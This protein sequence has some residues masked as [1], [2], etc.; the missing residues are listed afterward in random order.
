LSDPAMEDAQPDWPLFREFSGLGGW[1]DRLAGEMTILHFCHLHGERKLAPK[2]LP[3]VNVLLYVK[4]LLLR[5]GTVGDAELI[6]ALSSTKNVRGERDPEMHH[7]NSGNRWCVSRARAAN[8]K[9]CT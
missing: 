5:A 8:L 1:S 7:A 4:G 2:M 6:T 9:S 3:T